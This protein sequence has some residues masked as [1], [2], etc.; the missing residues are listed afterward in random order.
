MEYPILIPFAPP[1]VARAPRKLARPLPSP[2]VP[3]PSGLCLLLT[4]AVAALESAHALDLHKP[5]APQPTLTTAQAVHSLP[6]EQAARA[7]PVRLRATVTYYDP[8]IDARRGALFVHDSTGGVFVSLPSRPILPLIPGAEVELSG[9][10]AP[11][12]YAAIVDQA[13]LRLVGQSI[14]PQTVATATL[15]QML[16]GSKD[17]EWVEV[18]GR[19]HQVR[20]TRNNVTLDIATFQ[21]Q[22]TAISLRQ[23]EVN[24]ES[25]VDAKIRLRGIAAPVFDQKAQLVGV[26]IF[27]SSI[28]QI[29]IVEAPP[30]DTFAI[31]AIPIS[32]LLRFSPNAAIPQRV[33]VQGR[34]T[35]LWPDRLLCIQ[36]GSEGICMQSADDYKAVVGDSIDVIGFPAVK[37]FRPALENA[38]IRLSL[39]VSPTNPKPVSA[40]EILK[41]DYDSRLVQIDAE[42]IGRDLAAENPT[43]MLRDGDALFSAD[44]P[45]YL[46]PDQLSSWKVG[47]LLRVTGVCLLHFDSVANQSSE[48]QLRPDSF[49]LLLN[50]PRG[51]EV[52]HAP[53][54]WTPRH[55]LQAFGF[56][57]F[58]AFASL[59]WILVLRRQVDQQTEALRDSQ[60]RLR[61]LS[62]HDA[63]TRLPNRILLGDR[64]QVALQRARRF[65]SCLGL[66]LVDVDGF[67]NINDSLG[68]LAGD[69]V[70]CSLAERLTGS[71]RATDTVA[72]MGGD[73]FIVLL[74]DLRLPVE[75]EIIAAKIV[76]AV[77]LPID[78]G[79][80]QTAITVSIGIGVYP[81]GGTDMESMMQA[82][83]LALYIAKERG[84]NGYQVYR[85][86]MAR[87]A[88]NAT[89]SPGNSPAPLPIL[90]S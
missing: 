74:S 19:V 14:L 87:A 89:A 77:S 48:G 42:L 50:S 46:G 5:H 22:L 83:D 52:L 29:K 4:L 68:H 86:N 85:P 37:I 79:Q 12:D 13:H 66:L 88:A 71:V 57:G 24:Y 47:T 3:F 30:Q 25:L 67:K 65:E 28:N 21:G 17:C 31:P 20:F 41:G 16:S 45:K 8:Y 55:A 36:N 35:L 76:A 27:F 10:S 72:R 56:A 84:K 78:I 62:E 75:A 63:L 7:F 53:S 81:D 90:G 70:L 39:P 40:G 9:V 34:V 73:E 18:E 6:P 61:H 32:Q 38:S 59:A 49:R 51:V 1:K 69:K 43:L 54:W 58:I 33:H 60:Q 2:R 64:L 11:G 44:L 82:A 15:M 26:H 23:D 80:T